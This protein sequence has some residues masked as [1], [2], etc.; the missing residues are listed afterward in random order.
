[1][2]FNSYLYSRF[3]EDLTSN[4]PAGKHVAD[5][6]AGGEGSGARSEEEEMVYEHKFNGRA[7][8]IEIFKNMAWEA[9][10]QGEYTPDDYDD[11]LNYV[12]I[13]QQLLRMLGNDPNVR[14]NSIGRK[15]NIS[16]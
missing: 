12:S 8:A 11:P 2:Y 4:I 5:V 3:T 1:M 6:H 9:T 16:Y 13:Y 14:I 15:C 10:K 7:E